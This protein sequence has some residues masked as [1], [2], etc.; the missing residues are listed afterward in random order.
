MEKENSYC[1]SL[2]WSLAQRRCLPCRPS[3]KPA[4]FSPSL[5]QSLGP[6]RSEIVALSTRASIFVEKGFG[7]II[8]RN[9]TFLFCLFVFWGYFPAK[10]NFQLHCCLSCKS[11]QLE[12]EV[13]A[14]KEEEEAWNPLWKITFSR[15]F[16]S[17]LRKI[18]IFKNFYFRFKKGKLPNSWS[19]SK[20]SPSVEMLFGFK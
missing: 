13:N 4:P 2:P 9:S 7:M 16:D 20:Y 11:Y 6:S 14:C 8:L 3:L 1:C 19:S 17:D 5:V 10:I 18:M 12:T 15:T